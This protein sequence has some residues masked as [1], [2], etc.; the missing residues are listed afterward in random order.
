MKHI[1]KL[2]DQQLIIVEKTNYIDNHGMK[3]NGN[4]LYTI[5]PIQAAMDYC[6]RQQILRL[7][8]QQKWD[9]AQ[10]HL[11]WNPESAPFTSL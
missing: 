8:E 10:K 1:T 6:Y 3:W 2:E 9:Q 7:E 4:N 11:G 5:R